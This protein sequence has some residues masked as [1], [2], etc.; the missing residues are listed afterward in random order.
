MHDCHIRSSQKQYPNYIGKSRN[1]Y[2]MVLEWYE[3]KQSKVYINK[4]KITSTGALRE[5]QFC[6]FKSYNVIIFVINIRV[7]MQ[8]LN[9]TLYNKLKASSYSF[10]VDV[11]KKNTKSK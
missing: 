10:F 7:E 9:A 3:K 11:I 2:T 8:P 6:F 1:V 4:W 5:R